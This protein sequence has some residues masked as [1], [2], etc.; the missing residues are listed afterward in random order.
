MVR[1]QLEIEYHDWG[2]EVERRYVGVR[3]RLPPAREKATRTQLRAIHDAL[4]LLALVARV[5]VCAWKHV[6]KTHC[7]LQMSHY[8]EIA[9]DSDAFREPRF[10]FKLREYDFGDDDYRFAD[11]R[12]PAP[13]G[14]YCV[15]HPSSGHSGSSSCRTWRRRA[16]R[17]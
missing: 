9:L 10:V 6:L 16:Y 5:D 12:G 8:D 17:R 15:E 3:V 1:G 7:R 2:C 14:S 11:A 4:V 13:S